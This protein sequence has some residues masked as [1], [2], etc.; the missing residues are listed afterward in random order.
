MFA[1]TKVWRKWHRKINKNQKRYAVCSA[2]AASAVPALVMAR[3][4]RCEEVPE[5]PIVIENDF[6]KPRKT[7]VVMNTLRSLKLSKELRR[8][9]KRYMRP[10]KGKFRNRRWK[11][12]TG[13]L[14]VFA[15]DNGI[16]AAA[17]NIRGVDLCSV[18]HL[19]LLKLAPGGHVGRLI[20]WTEAAIECLTT[21]YGS[22]KEGSV[23]KVR[24]NGGKYHMPRPMMKNS[25]LQRII[26][27]P[28]VQG[29][30]RPTRRGTIGKRKRNP[31]KVP[32]LMA[33][34]NP[35]FA[36][37]WKEIKKT[38][39]PQYKTPRADK[40]MMQI[41]K[42]RKLDK[43]PFKGIELKLG[44]KKKYGAYWNN[45]FGDDKIFKNAKL[46]AAEKKAVEA[47]MLADEREKKGLDLLEMLQKADEEGD[48]DDS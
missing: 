23:M 30:L 4:H 46:L 3:G 12:R 24:R 11:N 22:Q 36:E 5:I 17:R 39:D 8:C 48:D 38:R 27:S 44:D 45:V 29:V 14:I 42:K 2:I 34:L 25:D 7:K 35:D 32:D 47:A 6:Q 1:P 31:L 13:P 16:G 15:K 33:E 20:I 26:L 37:S 18:Y 41:R 10:G 19:N 28:E 43:T 21:L 9:K 40:L